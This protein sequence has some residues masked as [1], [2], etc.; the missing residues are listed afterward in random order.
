MTQRR[1]LRPECEGKG[2]LIRRGHFIT[3]YNAQPV[4]RYF[5]KSCKKSSSSHT[6]L[7]TY[8]QKKPHLN[9][10]VFGLYA[11]A[12]TQRRIA[13]ILRINRKTVV[14]KFLFLAR[15]SREAHELWLLD[16]KSS[17]LQFD[18]MESFEHTRLKPLSIGLCVDE[19][20]AKIVEVEVATMPYRG[21]SAAFAFKKYGPRPDHRPRMRHHLLS[22]LA[23]QSPGAALLTDAHPAY[24][25]VIAEVFPS[26][27]HIRVKSKKGR[28]FRP[29]G[30]RRNVDDAL[31]RLSHTQAKLRHD[32]SRL[33]REVW[34]TTKK[35][36]R[37]QAHLD[38]YLAFQNDYNLPL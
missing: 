7:R 19:K 21:R 11:S 8:R 35:P 1:C 30:S 37:L 36:S 2:P 4:R 22:K 27:T 13:R 29:E 23:K 38:L 17:R 10:L 24:P 25:A 14:R 34:I 28:E 9:H 5:C 18:E 15:L 26:A 3:R 6:Y 12:M 20:S 33:L 16:F 32:L 31:F